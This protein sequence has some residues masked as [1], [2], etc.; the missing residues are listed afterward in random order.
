MDLNVPEAFEEI[1]S[2]LLKLPVL[3][4]TDNNGR[5]QLFLDISRTAAE[6]ALYQTQN[7]IQN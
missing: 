1:K 7:S 6:S 2:I 4:M 3:H 5:F